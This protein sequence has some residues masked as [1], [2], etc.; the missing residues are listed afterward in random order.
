MSS[1]SSSSTPRMVDKIKE[2]IKACKAYA[3]G[4]VKENW[5]QFSEYMVERCRDA[6]EDHQV[7]LKFTLN[8]L[9]QLGLPEPTVP[10]TFVMEEVKRRCEEEEG[11]TSADWN[12]D[13]CTL[14]LEWE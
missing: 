8:I 12:S 10:I 4:Y 6:H 1:S 5:T 14:D 7:S 13:Y 3:R 9:H 11:F 2:E